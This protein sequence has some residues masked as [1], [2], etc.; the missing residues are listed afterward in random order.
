MKALERKVHRYVDKYQPLFGLN[1][2]L[3]SISFASMDKEIGYAG[4]EANPVYRE[5]ILTF[6]LDKLVERGQKDRLENIVIHELMHCRQSPLAELAAD[7]WK[8]LLEHVEEGAT[9]DL[10]RMPIVTDVMG[11]P[12]KP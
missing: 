2:W 4:C 9:T 3:I 5:A 12:R 8:M 10:E 7:M 11:K 1:H 6:D